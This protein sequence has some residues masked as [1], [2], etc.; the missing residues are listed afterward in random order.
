MSAPIYAWTEAEA[1]IIKSCWADDIGRDALTLIVESLCGIMSPVYDDL[2]QRMAML[3]GR[4]AVGLDLQR[5]INLPLDRLIP[6]EP[7]DRHGP[8]TST[9]RARQA[10]SGTGKPRGR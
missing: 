1:K 9:E 5:A 8:I 7:N 2:P 3:E 10:V 4:R 6:E